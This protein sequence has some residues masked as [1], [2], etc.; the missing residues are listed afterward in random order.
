MSEARHRPS[1]AGDGPGTKAGYRNRNGQVVLRPTGLPPLPA[2]PPQS[3]SPHCNA[4]STSTWTHLHLQ[5]WVGLNSVSTFSGQVHH[6]A[7][8]AMRRRLSRRARHSVARQPEPTTERGVEL[9]GYAVR[10][11]GVTCSCLL[12]VAINEG[13]IRDITAIRDE[14]LERF[15]APLEGLM[16]A[17]VPDS[18]APPPVVQGVGALQFR[19]DNP[20]ID[21]LA[22]VALV[23]DATGERFATIHTFGC[24][25]KVHSWHD[26]AMRGMSEALPEVLRSFRFV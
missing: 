22:H 7:L 19:L 3:W 16:G 11:G 6:A 10:L 23:T 14:A 15:S 20:Y 1:R 13:P 5:S 17:L 2:E 9:R 18:T 21:G 25:A 24:A 12:E 26:E 8:G 4:A